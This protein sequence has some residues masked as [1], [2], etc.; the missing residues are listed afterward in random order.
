MKSFSSYAKKK[1]LPAFRTACLSD[2]VKWVVGT[3][4]SELER[5]HTSSQ[6]LSEGSKLFEG[7]EWALKQA[8]QVGYRKALSET[9]QQ[10]NLLTKV[11]H[12]SR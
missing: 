11:D 2:D 7:G 4:R 10:L 3:V 12:A 8:Y 9:L 6:A 1:D 5:A